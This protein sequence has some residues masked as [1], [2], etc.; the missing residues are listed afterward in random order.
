MPKKRIAARAEYRCDVGRRSILAGA[1]AWN[2][3]LPKLANAEK[4]LQRQQQDTETIHASRLPVPRAPRERF[5]GQFCEIN[6]DGTEGPD[7]LPQKAK[8]ALEL[9]RLDRDKC[10]AVL[11]RLTEALVTAGD[12]RGMAITPLITFRETWRAETFEPARLFVA[13]L[14][15]KVE[16]ETRDK[17]HTLNNPAQSD[18]GS[19]KQKHGR[20]AEDDPASIAL[21]PP[22]QAIFDQ[23]TDEGQPGPDIV[24]ALARQGVRG[25]DKSVVSRACNRPHMKARGVRKR[26]NAGYYKIAPPVQL[27]R[28]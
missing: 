8:E 23:L 11:K 28:N 16:V 22:E 3:W 5:S 26:R 25:I 10:R 14:M 27:K 7:T 13:E 15:A 21:T 6:S 1:R 19:G 4:R 18:G 12:E 9:R 2:E 24:A 20:P 17:E